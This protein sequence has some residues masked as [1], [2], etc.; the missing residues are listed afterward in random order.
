M[1]AERSGSVVAVACS[2]CES[3]VL[4]INAANWRRTLLELGWLLTADAADLLC[5]ACW[6][7]L[8]AGMEAA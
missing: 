3:P 2:G 6:A 8:S 5:P 4:V 1:S 7:S